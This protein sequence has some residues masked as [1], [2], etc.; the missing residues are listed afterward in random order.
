MHRSMITVAAVALSVAANVIAWAESR[1]TVVDNERPT[2]ARPTLTSEQK[3][4]N[5][6][7][8]DYVWTTIRNKYFDPTLGGL[9]WDQIR[10]ELR[11]KVENA[12]SASQVRGLLGDTARFAE[13]PELTAVCRCQPP[14]IRLADPQATR[15]A[16]E[17]KGLTTL[18]SIKMRGSS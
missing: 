12:E 18:D 14:R 10:D 5:L 6:D 4:L 2:S 8:F 3:Q 9:N 11:P 15:D 17:V 13:H 7:S 16:A 1:P